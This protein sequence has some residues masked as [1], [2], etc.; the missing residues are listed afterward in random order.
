MH[1]DN[2]NQDMEHSHY[3]KKFGCFPVNPLHLSNPQ[4]PSQTNDKL[5]VILLVPF[6]EGQIRDIPFRREY[7]LKNKQASALPA[8]VARAL[9]QTHRP[10]YWNTQ[11]M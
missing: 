10:Y 4:N 6:L 3:P 2:H 1:F 11:V 8:S 7:S 9:T 5:S